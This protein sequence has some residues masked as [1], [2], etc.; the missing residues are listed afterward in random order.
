MLQI[1][2]LSIA[3]F[4]ITLV[5]AFVFKNKQRTILWSV[6]LILFLGTLLL[7]G[8]N[9]IKLV[10]GDNINQT[11]VWGSMLAVGCA[12]MLIMTAEK[13]HKAL[14]YK[15]QGLESPIALEE[16]TTEQNACG[17]EDISEEKQCVKLSSKLGT[18]LARRIFNNALNAHL[19]E[20]ID[21]H[22]K[23]KGPKVQL[24]YMCGRIYCEDYPMYIERER[25]TYWI[26]GKTEFFPDSELNKLFQVKALGQSRLNR[27]ES[28]VPH[29][30][31]KIDI[32]FK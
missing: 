20:E 4:T 2:F 31:E 24:A 10:E 21:G 23:W 19:M 18:P 28:S 5:I 9:I 26:L 11:V 29:G 30:S 12:A 14:E 15:K 32:L 13:V 6:A 17:S 3:L 25:K 16:K 8:R 22:Y 1:S 27:D 7:I